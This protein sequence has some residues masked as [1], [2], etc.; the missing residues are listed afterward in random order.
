MKWQTQRLKTDKRGGVNRSYHRFWRF[1]NFLTS[2]EN[3]GSAH[4]FFVF[5]NELRHKNSVMVNP[6]HVILNLFQDLCIM[7]L[8]LS[9]VMSAHCPVMQNNHVMAN[10]IHVIHHVILNPLHVML[11]LFQHLISWHWFSILIV[12]KTLK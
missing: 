6:L 1:F 10:P 12:R 7:P 4:E 8:N 3:L 11:N 5:L 2:P 9:S